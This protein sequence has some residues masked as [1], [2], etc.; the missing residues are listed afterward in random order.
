MVSTII[1]V[2]ETILDL[3]DVTE[4]ITLFNPSGLNEIMRTM[5]R[6]KRKS[7]MIKNVNQ[8]WQKREYNSK[9]VNYC[10]GVEQKLKFIEGA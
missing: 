5:Q 9:E 6:I 1:D 2:I 4:K 7:N 3:I 10:E 8:T